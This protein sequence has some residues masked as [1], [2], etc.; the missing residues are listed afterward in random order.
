MDIHHVLAQRS[1]EV[2]IAKGMDE[3]LCN[4]RLDQY[5]LWDPVWNAPAEG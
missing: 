1:N 4:P 3:H 5:F 2:R